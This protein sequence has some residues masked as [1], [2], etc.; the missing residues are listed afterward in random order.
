ME[1][2]L[3]DVEVSISCGLWQAG[4]DGEAGFGDIEEQ[5]LEDSAGHE[6]EAG[7]EG[8]GV[9]VQQAEDETQGMT[10]GR[11]ATDG[12][13]HHGAG[14]AASGGFGCGG[15]DADGVVSFTG[16]DEA[17]AEQG[18]GFSV[19]GRD[20]LVW[21]ERSVNVGQEGERFW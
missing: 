15:D 21:V 17:D 20:G 13:G 9:E 7:V 11:G 14:D 3:A 10:G 4:G 8:E 6:A 12:F 5:I 19:T 18:A 1:S 2:R 16:V